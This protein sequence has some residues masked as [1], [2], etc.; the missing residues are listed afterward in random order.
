VGGFSLHFFFPVQTFYVQVVGFI[1]TAAYN[2]NRSQIHGRYNGPDRE[3]KVQ[4][5]TPNVA[6]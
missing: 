1:Q 6:K 2:V 5:E 4:T 3:Q